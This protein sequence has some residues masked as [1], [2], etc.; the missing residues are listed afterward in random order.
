MTSHYVLVQIL[1]SQMNQ[2]VLRYQSVIGSSN[3]ARCKVQQMESIQSSIE[4]MYTILRPAGLP[5]SPYEVVH[6][7]Q[8]P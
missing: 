2:L 4:Y 6:V 3:I 7:L 1:V 5:I 8:Q